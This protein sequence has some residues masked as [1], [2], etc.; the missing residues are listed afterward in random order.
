MDRRVVFSF[1]S[2]TTIYVMNLMCM[3]SS[4]GV[5]YS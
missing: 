5:V 4:C 3:T 1:S 2:N